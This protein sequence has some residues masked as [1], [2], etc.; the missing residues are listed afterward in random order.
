M[1]KISSYAELTKIIDKVKPAKYVAFD[2]ETTGLEWNDAELLQVC[3]VALDAD[4]N[5]LYNF[6]IM[7]KPDNNRN[8]RVSPEALAINKI[9]LLNH[10]K[11]ASE[12]SQVKNLLETRLFPLWKGVV[13]I[14]HNINFDISFIQEFIVSNVVWEKFVSRDALDTKRIASFLKE[15]GILPPD[16]K[17][18]LSELGKYFGIKCNH[19]HDAWNDTIV[20][21]E[22]LKKLKSLVKSQKT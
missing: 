19:Y 14:G 21:I 7:C 9:D 13:P 1:M 16:I 3:F 5:I 10:K 2:T 11:N 20:T 6:N 18:N 17:T 12:Y 8:F 22:V 15:T 4:L